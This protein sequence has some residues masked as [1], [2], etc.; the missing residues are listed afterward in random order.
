[1]GG[2]SKI[3]FLYSDAS[4]VFSASS[5]DNYYVDLSE[6]VSSVHRFALGS[7]DTFCGMSGQEAAENGVSSFNESLTIKYRTA[8]SACGFGS[9]Y[10]SEKQTRE[11]GAHGKGKDG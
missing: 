11:G 9:R 6:G 5:L 2:Y 1:M 8:G 7:C 3:S 4:F 10:L